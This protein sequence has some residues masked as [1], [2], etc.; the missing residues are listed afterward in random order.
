MS[1]DKGALH[2]NCKYGCPVEV[3]KGAD[4]SFLN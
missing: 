2:S 3:G 4:M 1:K